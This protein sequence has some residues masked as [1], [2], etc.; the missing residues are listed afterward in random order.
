[1]EIPSLSLKLIWNFM[2][3]QDFQDCLNYSKAFLWF[4]WPLVTLMLNF[5]LLVPFK[6]IVYNFCLTVSLTG[7]CTTFHKNFFSKSNFSNKL[8][9]NAPMQIYLLDKQILA[10][11]DYLFE[12]CDFPRTRLI[13]FFLEI[14]SSESFISFF[15]FSE[16]SS[17][18][19]RNK[20]AGGHNK[21]PKII[22][23]KKINLLLKNITKHTY[24]SPSN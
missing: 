16:N 2:T 12:P 11:F 22:W 3:F 1:M 15:L 13:C 14:L 9:S 6:T 21:Q 7:L 24:W 8:T 20:I 4:T 10:N 23:K 5:V 19:R 18:N 17:L